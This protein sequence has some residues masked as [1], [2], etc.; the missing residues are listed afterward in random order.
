MGYIEGTERGQGMMF[1]PTL[2]EYVGEN[3]EVRAVGAFIEMLEFEKLGFVRSR[4]AAEGRPGYDPRVIL[5]IFIWGHM[6]KVRSSRQLERECGRNVELMWL[7]GMLKPDYKTLCRFRQENGKAIAGTIVQFRI[8]CEKAGLLG[9]ELVAIDGSKFRAV[10]SINRNITQKK[11]AALIERQEREVAE[12]LAELE[13]A[14]NEDQGETPELDPEELRKR[15]ERMK[16]ELRARE[17]LMAD[18]KGC[19]ES[20]RS[21]TDPDARLMKTAHGSAVCYNLQVAVD[22]KYKLIVDVEVT[23]EPSDQSLLAEMAERA[24]HELGV[25]E[26]TVVADG[27]YFS[28]EAIKRC[29]DENITI[30]VP[31][32]DGLDAERR[33]VFS[34]D[35]FIYDEALDAFICPQGAYLVP[36]STG[37]KKSRR[38]SWK[39]RLY[40]TKQCLE[41][42]VRNQCTTSKTGRKIRRWIDHA[43]LD[44]LKARLEEN[45]DILRKRKTLVEH[46]FGTIKVSMNHERLLMKGIKNVATEM[47][48]TVLSYNFKRVISILGI[49]ALIEMLN[50]KPIR[51]QAA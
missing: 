39:F 26:L 17:E 48:L 25:E 14:D 24:K 20:Q 16:E 3:S 37:V 33:G 13:S 50:P 21:L 27:G 7:S 42:P 35:L 19:G 28:N 36:R 18:M 6:N 34:R 47:R 30:Y 51:P 9:K 46:P 41:C 29:E 32:R 12:Y 43:V 2:D 15:I 5:A 22:S 44:R 11:L 8:L 23:N 45:P 10:N 40:S 38:S 49:K 4:P 31:I 1:P